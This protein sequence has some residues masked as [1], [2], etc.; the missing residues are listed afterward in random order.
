MFV[1]LG[2]GG[3]GIALVNLAGAAEGDFTFGPTVSGYYLRA[4]VFGIGSVTA[5]FPG[6]ADLTVTVRYHRTAPNAG[7]VDLGG[8]S[9]QFRVPV[10]TFDTGLTIS[11]DAG[12]SFGRVPLPFMEE[13]ERYI[14]VRIATTDE[15]VAGYIAL[16]FER[17][18]GFKVGE[19]GS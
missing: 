17:E 9:F 4:F 3:G 8:R 5:G 1:S 12:P 7:A 13:G 2:S 14:N 19:I 18:F 16:D 15:D 11:R 10:G 6:G